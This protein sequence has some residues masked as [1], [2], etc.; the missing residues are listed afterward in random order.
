MLKNDGVVKR[1][2]ENF[3]LKVLSEIES[4]RYNK[5][6]ATR[7]YGFSDATLQN[8]IRRYSKFELLNQRVR[9]ETMEEKDRIKALEEENRKLKQILADKD[10][11]LLV[12]DSMLEVLR[13]QMGLKSIEELKKK[14]GINQ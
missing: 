13:K 14:Y 5:K 6:E 7:V 4:G 1:Y 12:S 10:L 3:K 8:W 11:K 9:I 2:S